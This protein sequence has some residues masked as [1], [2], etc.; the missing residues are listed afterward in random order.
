MVLS[1]PWTTYGPYSVAFVLLVFRLQ[2]NIQ[3]GDLMVSVDGS[4]VYLSPVKWKSSDYL[5]RGANNL[6]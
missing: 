2:V 4:I 1:G 3:D 6:S 5:S